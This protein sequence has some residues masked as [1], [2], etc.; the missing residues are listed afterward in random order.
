LG[1]ALHDGEIHLTFNGLLQSCR[2]LFNVT[3]KNVPPTI[4]E[5]DGT[6]ATGNALSVSWRLVWEDTR[7]IDGTIPAEERSYFRERRNRALR[8]LPLASSMIP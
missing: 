8:G 5:S 7:Y 1:A 2:Q 4:W 3:S 6:E